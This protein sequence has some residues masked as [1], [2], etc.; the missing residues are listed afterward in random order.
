MN[1]DYGDAHR[2]GFNGKEN[3]R[4]LQSD[5]GS[6][7]VLDYGFRIY[8]PAIARFLSVDPLMGSYPYY[9]PYQFAGNDVIRNV[10][11]DGLEKHNY[12]LLLD[13][14]GETIC[15][16]EFDRTVG[17]WAGLLYKEVHRIISPETQTLYEFQFTTLDELRDFVQGK[18]VTE[19]RDLNREKL[20][21]TILIF[22]AWAA[23]YEIERGV[24]SNIY[25]NGGSSPPTSSPIRVKNSL[26]NNKIVKVSPIA[27]GN[28]RVNSNHKLKELSKTYY[29]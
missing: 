11:V 25:P 2:Y 7:L 16:I 8:N 19:L 5:D 15:D 22:S 27:K 21:M 17:G 20:E 3:D 28:F 13:E 4:D 1:A 26:N 29:G 18:T 24:N 10:D 12:T 9:T 23:M 6:N 14:D